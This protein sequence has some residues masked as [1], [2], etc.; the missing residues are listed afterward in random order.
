VRG[1]KLSSRSVTNVSLSSA[2]ISHQQVASSTASQLNGAKKSQE[3]ID[4]ERAIALSLAE[5]GSSGPSDP[6]AQSNSLPGVGYGYE[7]KPSKPSSV[8]QYP[9]AIPTKQLEEEDPDLAAAI[10]ASLAEAQ[11]QASTSTAASAPPKSSYTYA[12]VVQPSVP[13]YEL[14]VSEFDALD[15]F[16]NALRDPHIRPE[17][18]N[19]LFTRADRHRGKMYRALE[20][21]HAKGSMLA[22]LNQ[23]LQHAV[24]LYDSLLERNVSRYSQPYQQAAAPQT[25]YQ[26]TQQPN[27][28]YHNAPVYHPQQQQ[29][30]QTQSNQPQSYAPQQQQY[31]NVPQMQAHGSYQEPRQQ[32]YAPPPSLQHANSYQY[33]DQSRTYEEQRAEGH[34]NTQVHSNQPYDAHYAGEAGP[35]SPIPQQ[36]TAPLYVGQQSALA[37]ADEQYYNPYPTVGQEQSVPYPNANGYSQEQHAEQQTTQTYSDNQQEHTTHEQHPLPQIAGASHQSEADLPAPHEHSQTQR[38][39]NVSNGRFQG[40]FS[41]ASFPVVPSMPVG[42][43]PSAPKGQF[44]QEEA[45]SPKQENRKEEALIEF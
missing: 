6:H 17:D 18:A 7:A 23:K 28:F 12:P 11:P 44:I 36:N 21:A 40:F 13:S 4:F 41:A 16:S 24:R 39:E 34:S 43:L 37:N 2:S 15:S 10:R 29:Q 25:Y 42:G 1:F 31:S 14:A 33:Q 3:E 5:S 38:P 45:A 32:E 35:T 22:E 9:S 20:D 27:Q 19:E 30:Q 26:N 8:S